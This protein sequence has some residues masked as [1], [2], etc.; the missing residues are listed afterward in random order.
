MTRDKP[1]LQDSQVAALCAALA[2]AVLMLGYGLALMWLLAEGKQDVALSLA[3]A[4]ALLAALAVFFGQWLLVRLRA[5]WRS[6]GKKRQSLVALFHGHLQDVGRSIAGNA[7]AVNE[8][9]QRAAELAQQSAT[10]AQQAQDSIRGSSSRVAAI[11]DATCRLK[12]AVEKFSAGMERSSE[13]A[14]GAIARAQSIDAAT[15]EL[16]GST[17]QIAAVLAAIAGI[18]E[19]IDLLALNATIEAARAGDAGKSFAVV[20]SEIKQLAMQTRKATEQIEKTLEHMRERAQAVSGC[21]EGLGEYRS[22]IDRLLQESR[23]VV[24]EQSDV[25]GYIAQDVEDIRA[26]AAEMVTSVQDIARLAGQSGEQAAQMKTH[27]QALCMQN[28]L[29]N[30]TVEEFLAQEAAL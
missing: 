8:R 13:A 30:K 16:S 15:S 22:E 2:A 23:K 6:I 4:G 18:T 7:E 24:L 14:R 1:S 28:I 20:A 10:R 11:G 26:R 19:K 17:V 12:E 3:G 25:V 9:L 27:M 21:F 5:S 29:L